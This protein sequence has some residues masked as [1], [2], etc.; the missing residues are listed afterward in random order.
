[1][2]TNR[3]PQASTGKHLLDTDADQNIGNSV[4]L[5]PEAGSGG[6]VILQTSTN[7][8][9]YNRILQLGGPSKTAQT[10][11]VVFAAS[12]LTG[13]QNPN[14]GYAGPVTGVLEFGNG[15][16]ITRVEVDVPVGPFNGIFQSANQATEP[17][18]GGVIVTVPT[19]VVNAYARYDNRYIQPCLDNTPTSI[20][21][22][23][24]VPF[25]GPGG[26]V[27][28]PMP[29]GIT[30]P[31][32]PLLVKAMA[33][34]YTR[35]FTR[36]YKTQFCYV[37]QSGIAVGIPGAGS[38]QGNVGLYAIPAYAQTVQVKRWPYTAG[39]D[40]FL[41]NGLQANP[42]EYYSVPSGQSPVIPIAGHE[43]IISVQSKDINADKVTFLALCYEVGV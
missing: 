9:S 34:Y 40:V 37:A 19:G 22:Y 25:L 32:E 43:H 10:T 36:A 21:Q 3:Y 38:P 11:S 15:G 35:H 2:A 20:A 14:P 31:A 41:W 16:R 13:S 29:P 8:T 33:A 24:G 18:D 4:P 1:M 12:R 5:Q 17:Q 28:P 27:V 23:L 42:E 26:P 6:T 7:G 30:A 39:L